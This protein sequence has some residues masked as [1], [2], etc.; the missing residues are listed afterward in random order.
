MSRVNPTMSHVSNL[1]FYIKFGS[2]VSFF[3]QFTPTFFVKM[4]QFYSS[5]PNIILFKCDNYVFIR[6]HIFVKYFLF[7][8]TISLNLEK[9]I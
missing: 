7:R 8:I 2:Y 3:F 6:I 5:P 9:K 1:M 4:K